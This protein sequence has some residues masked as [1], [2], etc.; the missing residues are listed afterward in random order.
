METAETAVGYVVA[1]CN[2]VRKFFNDLCAGQEPWQVAAYTFAAT[3][4][5]FYVWSVLHG[6]ERK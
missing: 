5:S 1:G 4:L 3:C 6:D 2:G